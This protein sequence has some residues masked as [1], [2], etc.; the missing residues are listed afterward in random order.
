[1]AKDYRAFNQLDEFEIWLKESNPLCLDGKT[2][3]EQ[4]YTDLEG[5]WR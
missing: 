2:G 4:Y 1:M 5:F 3:Y